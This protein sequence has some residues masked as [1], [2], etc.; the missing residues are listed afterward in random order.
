ME[1]TRLYRKF[2]QLP[3]QQLSTISDAKMIC[4]IIISW[5]AKFEPKIY[6]PSLAVLAKSH[7][8][9]ERPIE[10]EPRDRSIALLQVLVN[11]KKC[12]RSPTVCSPVLIANETAISRMINCSRTAP[13]FRWTKPRREKA[14]TLLDD[15]ANCP[16][17]IAV[18]PGSTLPEL[19]NFHPEPHPD[20]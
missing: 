17:S 6:A 11:R 12:H 13:V 19:T 15:L 4:C 8:E 1:D 5:E 3:Q 9:R 14:L 16:D 18:Q 2:S 10:S 7:H 20:M